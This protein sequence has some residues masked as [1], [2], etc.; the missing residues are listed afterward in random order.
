VTADSCQNYEPV[1]LWM[2]VMLCATEGTEALK[3]LTCMSW[4]VTFCFILS[5][6]N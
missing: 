4:A 3:L 2:C 6:L 1:L 5:Y